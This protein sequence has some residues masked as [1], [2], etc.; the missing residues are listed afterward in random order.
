MGNKQIH[1]GIR[2]RWLGNADCRPT[3]VVKRVDR[4]PLRLL[5][6]VGVLQRVL[7]WFSL[8]SL[9]LLMNANSDCCLIAFSGPAEDCFTSPHLP[10]LV[11]VCSFD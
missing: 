8:S 9:I 10:A 6:G 5:A 7:C 11:S 2:H 1:E 4:D 3:Q